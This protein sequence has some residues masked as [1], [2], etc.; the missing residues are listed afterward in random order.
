MEWKSRKIF[1]ATIS[2]CTASFIRIEYL[3]VS[4]KAA[5][6]YAQSEWEKRLIQISIGNLKRYS[7][8]RLKVTKI[9]WGHKLQ[10]SV[11]AI[12]AQDFFPRPILPASAPF[13]VSFIMSLWYAV[14]KR[15]GHSRSRNTTSVENVHVHGRVARAVRASREVADRTAVYVPPV[16]LA[17]PGLCSLPKKIPGKTVTF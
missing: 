15:P 10:V 16:P 6:V 11:D 9:I 8:H 2:L 5:W 7:N 4:Q 14:A 12:I 1:G 17:L 13:H 3:K